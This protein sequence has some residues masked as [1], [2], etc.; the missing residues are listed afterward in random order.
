MSNRNWKVSLMAALALALCAGAAAATP[1]PDGAVIIERVFNDCP[2]T[3]LTT[4]NMY[5][6][7]IGIEEV[8]SNCFGWANLHVWRFAVG[9][10]EALFPNNSAFRFSANL[11]IGGNGQSEAGLQV[12]P[13][14]SQADGRLNVR[15]TDG[16]VACFG[17]RLPF[18]SFTGSH[19][20]VYAKGNTIN[21]CI[22]YLPNG[23]S[24]TNPATI[25]YAL[26]YDGAMYNSGAL[27]FDQGNPAEDPPHGL[28]GILN[29]AHAGGY[30]QYNNMVGQPAGTI[31]KTEFCGFNFVDLGTVVATEVSSWGG[32]KALFR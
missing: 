9:G 12:A 20:V 8:G 15:T 14:W 4:T 13:W 32:V 17:G 22:T 3:T 23:L 24:E 25:Q 7:E 16:E 31:M 21:L 27:P 1:N 30:M 10:A 29:Y 11:T 26:F 6:F 18:Y 2:G 5:P 28:W 19:G